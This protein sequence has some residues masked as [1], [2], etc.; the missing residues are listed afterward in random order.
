MNGF[1]NIE[2]VRGYVSPFWSMN[3][4]ALLPYV[5]A[6]FKAERRL[7]TFFCSLCENHV[8]NSSTPPS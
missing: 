4:V 2:L 6:T 7:Q 5:H 1:V 8:G 3:Y